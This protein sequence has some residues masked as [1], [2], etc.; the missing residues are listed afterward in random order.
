[1]FHY[2]VLSEQEAMQE[3]FQLLKEGE[4][5]AVITASIDAMSTNSGNPMMDMTAAG[6]R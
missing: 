3:R 6:F 2:E 4:Y 5:D 1:M